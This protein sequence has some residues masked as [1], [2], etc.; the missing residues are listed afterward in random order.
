[1]VTESHYYPHMK[2]ECRID[3][4]C[5]LLALLLVYASASPAQTVEET[6]DQNGK[7]D[8]T[9]AQASDDIAVLREEITRL[10]TDYESRIAELEARLDAAEKMVQ[11][12]ESA[13]PPPE[14]KAAKQYES[15]TTISAARSSAFNPAI[16]V[17]FQGQAWS[18]RNDPDNYLVP[19]FPMGGET[20]PAPEGLSLAETELSMS[21]NVDDK[22]TAMLTLAL[23]VEGGETE[24][25]LEEAW[26]ETLGLPGGL[27]V[28]GGR[29]FSSIG[30]L[31]DR[32]F[33][34]WDFADQNLAY[35][36]FL[37][38]QY[39]DD[40]LQVR[41]LAP[42]DLYLEFT[43]EF[44][45]GDSY[46]AGGAANS[47]FGSTALNVKT[48]GDVGFS[49]S[50]MLGLSWLGADADERESGPEDDPLVFTGKTDLYIADFVWKWAPNG[51]SRQT[52]LKFQ[53]EYFWRNEDGQ[54][55]WVNGATTP[56]D[57]K[58]RG[59]YAQLIYQPFPRWRFGVRTDRLSGGQDNPVFMGPP[60]EAVPDPR[61]YSLMVDWSNSEFS[62]L[63]FQYN[64]DE[65]GVEDDNQFGLQYI[66]S[67]GAHGAHSF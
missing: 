66:F 23:A 21:A 67:I 35:Q 27:A 28:R 36:A 19:G 37:G 13:P 10:R 30:Y 55:T 11:T 18:Y 24:A 59:W 34:S 20:G 57:T 15:P 43:G 46:P 39:I 41:W 61:R 64:R 62:R 56:W 12:V 9:E 65:A 53:A 49:H 40:G 3:K 33:H 47:G 4:L 25:E 44:L 22:F 54:Y 50:W 60:I 63:R 32:H 48:G 26:V 52:N 51:N 1:M 42:T 14:T 17:T 16:G 58:Q 6:R 5:A 2:I 38:S 7:A 31:N 45:R 8:S 29:F